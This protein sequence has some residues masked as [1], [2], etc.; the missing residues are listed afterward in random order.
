MSGDVTDV[1]AKKFVHEVFIT[2]FMQKQI[3]IVPDEFQPFNEDVW[4][5]EI[6]MCGKVTKYPNQSCWG[7]LLGD[8]TT[9]IRHQS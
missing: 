6:D 8:V 4:F 5:N 2:M 3:W 1:V 7:E 9:Q